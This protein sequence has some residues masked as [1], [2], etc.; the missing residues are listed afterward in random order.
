LESEF[1]REEILKGFVELNNV[2][3]LFDSDILIL[4]YHTDGAFRSTQPLDIKKDCKSLNIKYYTENQ[5]E[6]RIHFTASSSDIIDIGVFVVSTLSALITIGQFLFK[7]YGNKEIINIQQFNKTVNNNFVYHIYEG[8][9]YKF[10]TEE[11]N[12]MKEDFKNH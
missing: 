12:K 1:S 7:K 2:D 5:N 3:D 11:I 6:P 10:C 8:D 4:P 9:V